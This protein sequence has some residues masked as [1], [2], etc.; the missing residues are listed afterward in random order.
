[1]PCVPPSLLERAAGARVHRGP[2]PHDDGG[3]RCRRP[4]PLR[5]LVRALPRRRRRRPRARRGRPRLQRHA[6]ARLHPRALQGQSDAV[7]TRRRPTTTSRGRSRRASRARRCRTSAT[8]SRA[9]EIAR[10]G[11]RRAGLRDAPAAAGHADR[12]RAAARGDAGAPRARRDA[13]QRPRLLDV[14][15]RRRPRRRPGGERSGTRTARRAHPTDLTRPWTFRGGGEPADVAMRL[16]TGLARHADA[17]LPRARVDARSLGRSPHYV[18][19]LARA[20]SLRRGG[21]R[22]GAAAARATARR[23]RRAAR[24]SSSRARAFS[25][26]SRCTRTAR[27]S[28]AASAP[29]ACASRSHTSARVYT[30]NLTPD[31]DDRPRHAGRPTTS[32]ARS[33]TAARATAACSTRSTCR[34]RSS[35]AL[36]RRA[37]STRSTRTCGRSRRCGTSCPPPQPAPSLGEARSG[38][39]PRARDGRADRAASYSPGERRPRARRRR[40]RAGRPQNPIATGRGV[41]RGA[42]AGMVVGVLVRR[43]AAVLGAR[44]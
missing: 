7:G 43:G 27:T 40:G 21:G 35:P 32:A 26:T 3:L 33:A 44:S 28:T 5:A 14:P 24:T 42:V 8:C 9:D 20:P 38:Q 41:R 39:A 17:E 6:A 4:R 1:M 36:D 31:P 19:S 37:T 34:G 23:P 16:A 25:A 10:A 15:R 2:G 11:R 22:R 12:P 29:A 30:R 18:R 13:L